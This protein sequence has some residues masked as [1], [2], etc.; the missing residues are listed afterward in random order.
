MKKLLLL[1]ASILL[2]C[3]SCKYLNKTCFYSDLRVEINTIGLKK[4]PLSESRIKSY[5]SWIDQHSSWQLGCGKDDEY[6]K[7]V[8]WRE[9]NGKQAEIL[10]GNSDVRIY[11]EVKL[12]G[13]NYYMFLCDDDIIIVNKENKKQVKNFSIEK[14]TYGFLARQIMLNGEPYLV[15]V[16]YYPTWRTNTSVLIIL[17]SDFS[18]VYKEILTSVKYSRGGDIGCI[19]SD[20]Y[21]N[22]II[23]K[24]NNEWRRW[25]WDEW[26]KINGDWVY[27]LP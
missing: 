11:Q 12:A 15:I 9:A 24:S 4:I 14:L 3:T 20:K 10:Y 25:E 18:I 26:Q 1:I 17:D 6:N 13:K 8:Q 23:I 7:K 16:T 21:S 2:F 5:N 27:Y 19:N 22:C